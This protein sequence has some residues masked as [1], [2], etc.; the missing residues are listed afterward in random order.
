MWPTLKSTSCT[1]VPEPTFTSFTPAGPPF[2]R[3]SCAF[4]FCV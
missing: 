2:L 1:L 3:D 4:F